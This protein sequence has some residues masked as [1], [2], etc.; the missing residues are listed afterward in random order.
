MRHID[1]VVLGA[2]LGGFD[3]LT[4]LLSRLPKPFPLTMAIVQHRADI[5]HHLADILSARTGIEVIEADDQASIDPG[6]VYVAPVNYHLLVDAHS[7][8]LSVD[9]PVHAARPS[10]DVLFESVA[11]CCAERTLAVLLT[12]SSEDGAAGLAAIAKRGGITVVQ[13]PREAESPIAP[14]AALACMKPAHV[15][16]IEGIAS[17]VVEVCR[18]QSRR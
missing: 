15:L 1:L 2:S 10:I 11:D 4:R 16:T 9:E 5:G 3:A 13:D 12:G 14:T 18:Q 6:R 17:L 8:E 7:F